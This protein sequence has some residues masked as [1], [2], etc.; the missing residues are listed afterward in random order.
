MIGYLKGIIVASSVKSI[1]LEVGGVGYRV[2]VNAKITDKKKGSACTLWIHSHQTSDAITLFGF[3]EE[4]DLRFFE[5]LTSVNGVGPKTAL[6]IL[7]QPRSAIEQMIV[8]NDAKALGRTPGIGAKTAARIVLELKGK[9]NGD[10]EITV[11]EI[12]SEAVDDAI[13]ALE[14]LGYKK[15][16]IKKVL[17]KLPV[18]TDSSEAIVSWFLK[19]V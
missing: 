11:P 1:V 15:S 14:S 6:E 17:T 19:A 8:A 7:E 10:G 2:G 16:Q 13:D 5:L 9:I 12:I 3:V 4:S 18:N